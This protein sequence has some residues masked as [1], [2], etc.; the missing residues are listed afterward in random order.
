MTHVMKKE[1]VEA[2]HERLV[3]EEKSRA[4][5]E[6]YMRD[7]RTFFRFV[8]DGGEVTKAVTRA[9]KEQLITQYAPASVNSMLASLNSFLKQNEWH[10]CMVKALKR[11]KESFRTEVRDLTREEYYCLL[12]EAVLRGKIRLYLMMETLCATGIRVSEL[13][14]ITVEAARTGH[15]MVSSKGKQRLVLIPDALC[16]KL[17]EYIR[18]WGVGSGSIFVTRSGKPVNRSNLFHDMKLLCHQA[19][20]P[21][22]KVYPHN[23][24]HLFAKTYYRAQND[25]IHL[26][27]ILGHSSIDTTRIYTMVSAKEEQ[28]QINDLN[29]VR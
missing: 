24:R 19:G 5:I 8:G 3:D 9:Y 28:R 22:E 29:L 15:A 2:F 21:E 4:T 16:K 10:E 17:E 12:D 27:D 23:L 14:Y 7:I 20:I 26:A 1:L 25:I 6:K 18:V 11:Q 13:Q